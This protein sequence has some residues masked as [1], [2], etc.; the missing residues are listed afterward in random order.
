[1][2]NK[3]KAVETPQD[4]LARRSAEVRRIIQQDTPR[5]SSQVVYAFIRKDFVQAVTAD[6]VKPDE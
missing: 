1:M 2:A 5:D 6:Y 4:V 3:R